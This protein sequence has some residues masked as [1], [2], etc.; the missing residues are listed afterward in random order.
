M[1]GSSMLIHILFTSYQSLLLARLQISMVGPMLLLQLCPAPRFRLTSSTIAIQ[2]EVSSIKAF[3]M[4]LSIAALPCDCTSQLFV[5]ADTF[6]V[7][8]CGS[9]DEV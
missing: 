1:F 2:A 6:V 9:V 4:D 3:A 5:F 8:I 7:I